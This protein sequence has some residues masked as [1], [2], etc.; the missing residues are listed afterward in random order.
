[1]KDGRTRIQS[2]HWRS[3]FSVA[4]PLFRSVRA[5]HTCA[6]RILRCRDYHCNGKRIKT[7]VFKLGAYLLMRLPRYDAYCSFGLL[8]CSLRAS[9]RNY[10]IPCLEMGFPIGNGSCL[11]FK[12]GMLPTETSCWNCML[13]RNNE[14][15]LMAKTYFSWIDGWQQYLNY[16]VWD[17]EV[18]G[19]FW[20]KPPISD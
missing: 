20:D 13:R 10:E 3:R 19:S 12:T 15:S 7:G 17:R 4:Q 11:R 5:P 18:R 9:R 8:A 1:M 14:M 6:M 2:L 16:W